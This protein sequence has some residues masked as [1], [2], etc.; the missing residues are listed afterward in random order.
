MDAA[1]QVALAFRA[2]L[3][4]EPD[5]GGLATY[6]KAL[7]RRG[8]DMAWLVG[9]LA[10]SD[11]FRSWE[12]RQTAPAYPLDSAPPLAIRSRCSPAEQ[13]ALWDAVA[14]VW[15]GLGQSEP[16]W[17]VLTEDRFRRDRMDAAA[18]AAFHES[19]EE[20][21]RRLNA[22]LRRAGW[23]LPPDAV[24]AEYG[25]GVG[26]ITRAL[27]RQ[28]GRVTGFDVSAPHLAQARAQIAA[29]QFGNAGFVQVRGPA[30]L[31]S[32]AGIDLFY[33]VISLQHSPP[34]IIH[35]VLA[36]AFG[37]LRP[38]G[39]A[40]FQVPTYASGYSYDP[41]THRPTGEMEMHVLPQ[42]TILDLAH[43]AGLVAAEVQPDWCV[44]RPGEWISSTF[45]LL[46]P[47]PPGV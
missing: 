27:A 20:E 34:P 19:G 47:A 41:A 17:S 43:G 1:A 21:V 35:D 46:K 36:H 15:S 22:W 25:C 42:R 8:H 44:G 4:R 23:T 13:Q 32:L 14:Q 12:A 39:C 11:E 10:R 31:Q 33:S 9:E 45:L 28:F 6:V 5:A 3:R 26:R 24:C 18:L 30:D 40:F 7:R 29:D 2:V 16:H 38:G 37:G